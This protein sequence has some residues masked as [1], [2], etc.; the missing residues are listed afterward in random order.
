MCK[1]KGGDAGGARVYRRTSSSLSVTFLVCCF[2]LLTPS[3]L[4]ADVL[5]LLGNGGVPANSQID[6]YDVTTGTFVGIF[7]SG[8]GLFFPRG[9]AFGPDGNLFVSSAGSNQVLEYNGTTGAFIG[10]FASGNGLNSPDGLTF[11]PD[12]N[13]YVVDTGGCECIKR[14]DGTTGAFL[15]N[16]ANV[17]D[18]PLGLTFG[19]NGELYVTLAHSNEV[20]IQNPTT[21]ATIGSFN[22]ADGAQEGLIFGPDGDL[23]ING[24]LSNVIGE[25]TE[26]GAFLRTFAS[27]G[28]LDGPIGLDFGPDG[29]LYAVNYNSSTVSVFNGS[30][31]TAIDT[32]SGGGLNNIEYLAFA[33]GQPASAPE[34]G[35]FALLSLIVAV[36]TPVVRGR[37]AAGRCSR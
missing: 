9:L 7:A 34:P 15:G 33:A 12:G 10:N 1:D 6:S 16:L 21:G 35:T 19:P 23:Y 13:L 32:I 14:Y 36:M 29:N 8:G 3:C 11:G 26:T 37:M 5:M 4:D 2:G 28:G 31:G 24:F 20:V 30:S 18:N 22:A 25:Y 27:G 17:G